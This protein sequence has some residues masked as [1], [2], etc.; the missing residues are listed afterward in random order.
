MPEQ[1]KVESGDI[2]APSSHVSEAVEPAPK[3]KPKKSTA[4][5]PSKPKAKP[6]PKKKAATKNGASKRKRRASL[7]DDELESEGEL[8]SDGSLSSVPV[9][10]R[11]VSGKGKKARVLS[12]DDEDE[13]DESED[14][15]ISNT[16][17]VEELRSK[18]KTPAKKLAPKSSIAS[19]TE[20]PLSEPVDD[21][22]TP[23]PPAASKNTSSSKPQKGPDEAS[24]PS[25][26]T[27]P[28]KSGDKVP[29]KSTEDTGSGSETSEVFDE[30]P[31]RKRKSKEPAK[32]GRKSQPKVKAASEGSSS[33]DLLIKQLQGQLVKCGVRKIWGFELKKYGDDKSAKIRHLKNMLKEVGMVGRFSE[34]RAREIK[35]RRELEADL[36]AVKEGEKH[37]GLSRDRPAR[38]SRVK[39]FRESTSSEGDGGDDDNDSDKAKDQPARDDDEDGESDE[40]ESQPKAR[41]RAS[42]KWR[43]DLA[44]LGDD[45][46]SD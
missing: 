12:D 26:R 25:T 10:R 41:R 42:S 40:E 32:E 23:P 33:E 19:D 30:P 46:E 18:P 16:S 22:P 27:T 4:K 35:E 7:S 5:S 29:P 31:K 20:S 1:E 2:S 17:E 21:D 6:A 34:A 24:E 9:K 38:R 3:P 45:S 11:R 15:I 28:K 37:W 36:D 14:D 44:F 8:S 13:D 39:T 43:A